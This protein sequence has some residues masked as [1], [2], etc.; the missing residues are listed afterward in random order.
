[1]NTAKIVLKII[2][3]YLIIAFILGGIGYLA[4]K[5]HNDFEKSIISQAQSQLLIIAQSEARSIEKDIYNVQNELEIL[6]SQAEIQDSASHIHNKE[7]KEEYSSLEDSYKDIKE[8]ADLIYLIDS[9]GVVINTGPFKKEIIGQDL[10][11]LSDVQKALSIRQIYTSQIFV[12][13]SGK[14]AISF[15]HPIFK[16]SEFIGLLRAVIPIERINKVA[17]EINRGKGRYTF[18]LDKSATILSFP[19]TNYIGKNINILESQLPDRDLPLFRDI[20]NKM[21]NGQ[22]GMVTFRFLST[23]HKPGVAQILLAFSPIRLKNN[24]WSIGEVMDYAMISSPVNTNARDNIFFSGF[25][26]LVIIILAL[27]FFLQQKKRADELENIYKKL[28]KS[29]LELKTAQ[30]QLIQAEKMEIVGKLAAG[31]AHEVKN[32]LAIIIQGVDYLKERISSNDKDL[33]LALKDLAEAVGRADDVVKGLLDFSSSA[34]LVMKLEDLNLIIGNS[35]L[36]MRHLIDKHQIKITK[37]FEENIPYIEVDKNR[38]EQVFLNLIL[39][40]IEAMPD[41][42]NLLICTYLDKRQKQEKWVVVQVEDSG[43]G[44]PEDN[45]KNMFEP[46]FTTKRAT[47]G[48]GLGLSIVKNII[49]MHGGKINIS[50]KKDNHGARVIILFKT[51]EKEGP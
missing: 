26:L 10:S 36:L 46:F 27:N 6:S 15:I 14:R 2:Y 51:Q 12:M 22:E 3:F 28:E 30:A 20:L 19:D 5:N 9:R 16:Q 49:E 42:G 29:H 33:S 32:P 8:M 43:T 1:M 17:K 48:T 47:G 25:V 4:R 24:L 44:I 13:P 41:G 34:K 38:I 35:L 23:A 37:N 7:T 31:V 45:L 18:I 40:A 21:R 11:G 50:N 39:N